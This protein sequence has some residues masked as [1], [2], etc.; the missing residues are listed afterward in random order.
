MLSICYMPWHHTNKIDNKINVNKY[1]IQ[2]WVYNINTYHSHKLY[3]FMYKYLH[4]D[5]TTNIY[6]HNDAMDILFFQK[7]TNLYCN[8]FQKLTTCPSSAGSG[9]LISTSW[10][11]AWGGPSPKSIFKKSCMFATGLLNVC[12]SC[13]VSRPSVAKRLATPFLWGWT[14]LIS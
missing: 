9:S 4:S 2:P 13:M 14:N 10:N 7:G 5:L 1:H 11:L 12:K 8:S 3:L 6:L